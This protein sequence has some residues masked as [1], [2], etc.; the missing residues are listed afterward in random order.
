MGSGGADNEL[1]GGSRSAVGVPVSEDAAMD[2]SMMS[3]AETG[4]P[5]TAWGPVGA[6]RRREEDEEHKPAEFLVEPDPDTIFS[7]T[8]RVAPPV[9]GG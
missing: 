1:G 8:E 7:V 2:T 4:E 6:G 9:I 3:R 5:G